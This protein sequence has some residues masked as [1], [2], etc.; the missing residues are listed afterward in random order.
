[1]ES[2]LN[3]TINDNEILAF[4][5]NIYNDVT[6]QRLFGIRGISDITAALLLNQNCAADKDLQQEDLLL[7]AGTQHNIYMRSSKDDVVRLNIP[8]SYEGIKSIYNLENFM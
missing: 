4:N 1:M 5:E 2:Y 3:I 8:D 7:I 6:L